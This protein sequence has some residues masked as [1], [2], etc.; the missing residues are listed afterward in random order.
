[1]LYKRYFGTQSSTKNGNS[2]WGLVYKQYRRAETVMDWESLLPSLPESTF[3]SQDAWEHPEKGE[4]VFNP[5]QALL[6]AVRRMI[7]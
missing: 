3:P 5:P 2:C 4:S 1:M 7:S 6:T